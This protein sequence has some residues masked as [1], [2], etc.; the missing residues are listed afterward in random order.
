MKNGN[1]NMTTG[2]PAKLLLR[3]ALPLIA[4]NV[5]QQLYTVVDTAI[6]GQ[7]VGMNALA[8]LGGVD[9]MNWMYLGIAQGFAQGFSVRMA[10]KY[11]QGDEAGLKRTLGVSAGLSALVAFAT[12]MV[13]QLCLN[14]FLTLLQVKE[15]LRPDAEL[16]SR[17]ILLG[18]PAMV[19][20]NFTASV[21]RAVGDSRTPLLAMAVA[22]LSNIVLDCV[23]VFWLNWGIAGAAAAT[24]LAQCLAG[25]LCTLRIVKTPVLRFVKTDMAPDRRLQRDLMGL[26]FPVAAQNVIISVGGMAVQSV[27]NHFDTSFIAG[28]T[29]TNKLYGL[30][31]IAAVSY[32]YAMT[33]Y[34]G[35]NF[36]AT[37]HDRIRKGVRWSVIISLITS[38]LIGGL[39]LILGR[40]ITML[41]ISAEDAALAAAA[42]ETAYRYLSVMALCLPILYLLYTFRSALQGMGDTR[43]PLLSGVMEFAM[44]VGT[45]MIIGR[46]LWREGIFYAELLAWT[47]AAALLA[48]AYYIRAARL[49]KHSGTY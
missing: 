26:G 30:L 22:A 15:S 38:A 23:T 8:A 45:A 49:E 27:V 6:V 24:V 37:L 17:I 4:G 13:A 3:F 36:G 12:L 48:T 5:F 32:G 10:Q 33:T 43:I 42:G 2:H 35:Q 39:M 47:G 31:E 19:F 18:V 16:Y 46:T 21:L 28:F 9:W 25:G 41:F 40:P 7:G 1:L 20:Y 11:G 34:T 44:R 14:P 29:A